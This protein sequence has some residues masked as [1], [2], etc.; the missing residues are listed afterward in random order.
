MSAYTL[1]KPLRDVNRIPERREAYFRS[2][3]EFAEGYDTGVGL[4]SLGAAA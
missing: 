3:A 1:Q 2:P 4:M